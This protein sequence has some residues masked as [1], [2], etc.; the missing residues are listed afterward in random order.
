MIL[1]YDEEEYYP[2]LELKQANGG[3]PEHEIEVPIDFYERYSLAMAEFWA[4]Q[5]EIKKMTGEGK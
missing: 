4:V 3:W 5:R 1:E 2:V